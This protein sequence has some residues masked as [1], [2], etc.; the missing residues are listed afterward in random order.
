MA[1]KVYPSDLTDDEWGLLEPHLP[2]PKPRG[3]PRLHG[4]REILDAVFYVLK[5]GCQWRMLPRDFPPWKTAFHY[6]RARRLDG[7]WE[8]TNRALRRL[9]R[10]KLGR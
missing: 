4:P 1:S 8:R 9:L 6:F 3:R 7:T 5:S 2:A 10:E